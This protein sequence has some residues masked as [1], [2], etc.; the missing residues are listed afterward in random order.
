VRSGV[1]RSARHALRDGEVIAGSEGNR[2]IQASSVDVQLVDLPQTRIDDE[3]KLRVEGEW[4]NRARDR[5]GQPLGDVRGSKRYV[6]TAKAVAHGVKVDLGVTG[7]HTKYI[8]CGVELGVNIREMTLDGAL[9]DVELRS[10]LSV[11]HSPGHK[12]YDLQFTGG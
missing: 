9:R 3:F 1:G 12:R 6:G 10:Y 8:A 7:H 2:A 4:Q 11:A 5:T